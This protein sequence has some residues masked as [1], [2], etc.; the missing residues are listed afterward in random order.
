MECSSLAWHVGQCTLRQPTAWIPQ[1]SFLSAYRR[2]IGRRGPVRQLRC[3]QGTNF[4]GAKPEYERNRE[5][6]NNDKIRQELMKDQCDWIVFKMNVPNASHMGGVWE[7]QIRTVRNV[8]TVLLDQHGAQLD[9][10]DLRTFLVEAESIVNGRPLTVDYLNSP[11]NPTPLTPN[12]LLTM[13][14]KI[15]LPPPSI[16]VKEDLY[17]TKRWHR[18]QF[19]ANLFWSRWRKEYVQPLQNRNKWITPHKNLDVNFTST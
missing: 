9:D 8:L 18:A 2:F 10:Q 6:V 16:F 3:D 11:D 1:C 12:N 14:T 13:K 4:V 5:I 15:V 7:R 17:C 19:L